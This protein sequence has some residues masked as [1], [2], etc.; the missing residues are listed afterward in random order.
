MD[1]RCLIEMTNLPAVSVAAQAERTYLVE[2]RSNGVSTSHTVEV[3]EGLAT[4]LGWGDE[5]E[6]E[7]VRQ[8]FLFLLDREP[9]NSI[10]GRFS[11]DTIS[12]YFPEY[13]RQIR[14]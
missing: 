1:Q 5:S 4:E 10:L 9:A 14:R 13:R 8:S 2:V 12:R 11:L 6:A 7:L 3:P